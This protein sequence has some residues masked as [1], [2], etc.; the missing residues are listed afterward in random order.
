MREPSPRARAIS[1]RVSRVTSN[2]DRFRTP[3]GLIV[4]AFGAFLA[5]VAFQATT[6]PPFQ[7]KYELKV[8]VPS[9]APVLRTG[10]AVRIG[11]RLAGLISDVEPDRQNGGTLVTANLTKPEFRDLSVDTEAY[12]RVHSIVYETYLELRP[13]DGDETLENGD[14]LA[15]AATSGVD[16]LEV[17]QLFDQE[18]REALSATTVNVG[19]GVAGR[20]RG[21]NEA[22]ADLDPLA[23]DAASQL[24]AATST[25]GAISRGIGGAA[26][27]ADGLTGAR[28]DDVAALLRS[29]DAVTGTVAN[30]REDLRQAIRLLPAFED[31]FLATA[32]VAEPLLAD[33]KGLARDLTPAVR[34]LNGLLPE[35][36]ALL[37]RSRTLRDEVARITGVADPVLAAAAPVVFRLFPTMT[38]LKPLNRD[39]ANLKATVE[40]Y[41]PEI[42]RAG[43]RLGRATGVPFDAGLKPGAPAGRVVPVVTPHS[44]TNPIPDPGEAEEDTC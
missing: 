37:D 4:L 15:S 43:R 20:G 2:L 39:L 27:T 41:K 11:G 31:Q 13:G 3:L 26:R 36:N 25:E 34:A 24:E 32:P 29:G 28:P 14:T 8:E 12:V 21:L 7:A 5:Y 42:R 22:L 30:R 18:A 6:G 1:A 38:A 40:P 35:L 19:F 10:Q 23:R 17:V 16:L 44:C 33:V 9:D